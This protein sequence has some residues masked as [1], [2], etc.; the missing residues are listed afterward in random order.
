VSVTMMLNYA[1][2]DPP[3]FERFGL[4]DPHGQWAPLRWLN[5]VANVTILAIW[6]VYLFVRRDLNIALAGMVQP[7]R[8]AK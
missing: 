7:S 2:H 5:A 4:T 1:L 3:L 6:M 8:A